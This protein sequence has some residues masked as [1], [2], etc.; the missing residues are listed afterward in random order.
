ML[1]KMERVDDTISARHY[2]LLMIMFC[3]FAVSTASAEVIY[4]NLAIL[5]PTR[6]VKDDKSV[7][8]VYLPS[9]F[10]CSADTF[11]V[12]FLMYSPCT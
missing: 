12:L 11:P 8:G 4:V 7:I 1:V 3:D 6:V 2:M 10:W 5:T 9:T